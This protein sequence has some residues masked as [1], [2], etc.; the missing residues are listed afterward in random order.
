VARWQDWAFQ[1]EDSVSTF[2]RLSAERKITLF[3]QYTPDRP[4]DLHR[5]G[6][7]LQ[8][9]FAVAPP[10][11]VSTTVLPFIAAARSFFGVD[12]LHPSWLVDPHNDQQ[13]FKSTSA[14]AYESFG[15]EPLRILRDAMENSPQTPGSPNQ[16]NMIQL[17][18]GGGVPARIARDAT[19]LYHRQARFILQ[20]DAY[21][22]APQDEAAN[23]QW[24]RDIR[25]ALL[26]YTEGAY[27]NYHDADLTDYLRAYYGTNLERLVEVKRRYDPDN[28]FRFPQS[29]PTQL[30]GC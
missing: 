18:G 26:P 21:W 2:L 1:V 20:Y 15:A 28:V 12:P 27:V 4:E 24:V 6:Q 30:P 8:E 16:P 9:L 23:V 29:I 13:I 11:S 17:L 5:G 22:T 7:L 3:G 19:A 14:F 10:Q 25:T